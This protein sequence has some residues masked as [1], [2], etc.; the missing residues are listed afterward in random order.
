M[1]S[2]IELLAHGRLRLLTV[3]ALLHGFGGLELTTIPSDAFGDAVG[4][5]LID[6]PGSKANSASR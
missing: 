3:L 4:I 2:R 6:G 5:V 1:K